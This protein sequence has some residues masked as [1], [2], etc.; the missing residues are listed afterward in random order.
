V[1]TLASARGGLVSTEYSAEPTH[2]VGG[3]AKAT[4]RPGLHRSLTPTELHCTI[5]ARCSIV[6]R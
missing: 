4:A 1:S 5:V 2:A 6:S 3:A